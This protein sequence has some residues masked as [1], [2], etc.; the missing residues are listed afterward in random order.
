MATDLRDGGENSMDIEMT[1]EVQSNDLQND[2]EQNS[3][4][5]KSSNKA[6]RPS[7]L[8]ILAEAA[9]FS[10][11][12]DTENSTDSTK[13]SQKSQNQ[14]NSPQKVQNQNSQK[15]DSNMPQAGIQ[16]DTLDVIQNLV[17]NSSKNV[18]G[19]LAELNMTPDVFEYVLKQIQ[20]RED[21]KRNQEEEKR[22]EIYKQLANLK[23]RG[24]EVESNDNYNGNQLVSGQ[25]IVFAGDFQNNGFNFIQPQKP[26]SLLVNQPVII[27]QPIQFSPVIQQINN[28]ALAQLQAQQQL[29]QKIYKKRF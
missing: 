18:A 20:K 22:A 10:Q 7:G 5:T 24:G 19:L 17:K 12:Q 6:K 21:E 2:H 13:T 3:K 8:E 28:P 9:M 23:N 16:I 27:Q 1:N 4:I 29:L 15:Q 25:N 26:T 11:K 14:S